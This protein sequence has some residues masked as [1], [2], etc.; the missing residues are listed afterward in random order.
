MSRDPSASSMRIPVAGVIFAILLLGFA[1]G[2]DSYWKARNAREAY[3][4]CLE[5][6][7]RG[8]D[9][10]ERERERAD[11]EFDRYEDEA[12]RAWGCENTPDRCRDGS[13][14]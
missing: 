3:Y 14:P 4:A 2:C 8:A 5:D 9:E 13:G 12:Q 10:C 11:A 7:D 1:T 6:P